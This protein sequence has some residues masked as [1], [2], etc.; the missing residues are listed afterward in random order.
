MHTYFNVDT[1]KHDANV[2]RHLIVTEQR[3][4]MADAFL[5]FVGR[6][7]DRRMVV[8]VGGHPQNMAVHSP[9]C[10][11]LL[12]RKLG[13][14]ADRVNAEPA[15]MAVHPAADAEH[16]VDAQGPQHVALVVMDPA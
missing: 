5:H 4:M 15:Q 10:F 8:A 7:V 1:Q 9:D 3:H 16:L 13:Q 14:I 2:L 6:R 12:Q 11:S